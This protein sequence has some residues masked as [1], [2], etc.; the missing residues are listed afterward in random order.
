[1]NVDVQVKYN[2]KEGDVSWLCFTC[3]V[4]WAMAD[5]EIETTVDDFNSEYYMGQTYCPHP[6]PPVKVDKDD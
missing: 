1:M 4:R 3:A 6:V 2:C 5:Y